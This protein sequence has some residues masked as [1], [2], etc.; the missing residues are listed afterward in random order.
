MAQV[1]KLVFEAKAGRYSPPAHT[2]HVFVSM[3][4][5]S[6]LHLCCACNVY[7]QRWL[8]C[9]TTRRETVVSGCTD[10]R[11]RCGWQRGCGCR[12]VRN[13]IDGE[14]EVLASPQVSAVL[15]HANSLGGLP[16]EDPLCKRDWE[17]CPDGWARTGGAC[18]AP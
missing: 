13:Q 15:E 3:V 9:P 4:I 14:S 6:F 12:F 7:A 2:C 10:E 17:G 8:N 11:K 16:S 18:R 1:P 5:A